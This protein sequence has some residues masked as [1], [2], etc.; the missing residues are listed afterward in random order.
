MA[1]TLIAKL[2]HSQGSSREHAV[3]APKQLGVRAVVAK[4]FA[5]IH[6]R[7]LIAQGLVPLTF[8]AETDY[9]RVQ[10]GDQW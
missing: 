10:Q 9:E 5:R 8:A 1:D 3:L 6:Q 4:S 7:N 2:L